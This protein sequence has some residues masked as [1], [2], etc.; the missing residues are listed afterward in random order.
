[1][2]LSN[3]PK[4]T[5]K[6]NKRLGRGY[7]SGKGGHTTNRGMKGQKSRS[8]IAIWFEGGQLPLI[9]RL[10][11]IRGKGR[12]NSLNPDPIEI[13]LE[14]LTSFKDGDIVDPKSLVDAGLVKQKELT[15]RPIKILGKGEVA[16]ALTVKVNTSGSAQKKIE[17]A[18]GTVDR[19]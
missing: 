3:L 11:F 2:D 14:Q 6:K 18:G 9:R 5:S 12:F 15:H 1:M 17:K 4:T 19:G 13:N 16:V 8:S 10:P 7:G